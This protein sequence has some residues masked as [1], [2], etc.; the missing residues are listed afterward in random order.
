MMYIE[1]ASEKPLYF[2]KKLFYFQMT[3]SIV[4]FDVFVNF[5]YDEKSSGYFSTSSRDYLHK[6][7]LSDVHRTFR[8]NRS[9]AIMIAVY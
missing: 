8:K 4:Q 2:F 6:T 1:M 7:T 9:D 5:N 3:L